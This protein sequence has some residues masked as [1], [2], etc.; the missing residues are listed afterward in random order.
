MVKALYILSISEISG[1]APVSLVGARARSLGSLF[2]AGFTVPEGFAVTSE[3]LA[4]VMGRSGITKAVASALDGLPGAAPDAVPERIESLRKMFLEV[5]IPAVVEASIRQAYE[6]LAPGLSP[7]VAVRIS[8]AAEGLPDSGFASTMAVGPDEVVKAVHICWVSYFAERAA[9]RA[10][11]GRDAFPEFT[12][13]LVLRAPD[14]EVSG[15]MFTCDP[16][17]GDRQRVVINAGAQSSPEVFNIERSGYSI[18]ERNCG[19]SGPSGLTEEFSRAL[20]RLGA[21]VE[22]HFKAPQEIEW[23]LSEGHFF[24]TGARPANIDFTKGGLTVW[25]RFSLGGSLP[26]VAT[27]FTWSMCRRYLENSA[28]HFFEMLEG[29]PNRVDIWGNIGGRVYLNMSAAAEMLEKIPFMDLARAGEFLGAPIELRPRAAPEPSLL[30]KLAAL[31]GR[32]RAAILMIS[33]K[34]RASRAIANFLHHHEKFTGADIKS[35]SDAALYLKFEEALGGHT[36]EMFSH[37]FEATWHTI[38][39]FSALKNLLARYADRSRPVLIWKL[40]T[41]MG[42]IKSAGPML[43]IWKLGRLAKACELT[44]LIQ[45][46][47]QYSDF[48]SAVLRADGDIFLKRFQ[49]FLDEFGQRCVEEAELSRPRWAENPDAV[50]SMIET[51]LKT[52]DSADPAMWAERLRAAAR[53]AERENERSLP[54]WA[55]P[56]FR[57]LLIRARNTMIER[58]TLKFHI[59]KIFSEARTLAKEAGRRLAE[60]GAIEK[61][62]DVFYLTVEELQK[63]LGMLP[64]TGDPKEIVREHKQEYEN[65]AASQEPPPVIVG[66][67]GAPDMDQSPALLAD[68]VDYLTGVAASF[69]T[70]RGPARVLRRPEEY[71]RLKPGDVI[72]APRM[73]INWAPVLTLAGAIVTES[74]GV[75]SNGAVLAREAGMPMVVSVP[76]ACSV[77]RDGQVIMVD[78]EEGR[79]WLKERPEFGS[80]ADEEKP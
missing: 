80:P 45:T 14:S 62:E 72:V 51:T 35:R 29:A 5:S 20:A 67:A 42:G 8:H 46:R 34:R 65:L 54:G 26:G 44:D 43:D 10:K 68:D 23:S 30:G 6:N 13:V 40:F 58:D 74:G 61:Q 76:H 25:G 70:H 15:I 32:L 77:F 24:I 16:S 7:K 28:Q 59:A 3:A 60:R 71:A 66:D 36:L 37:L 19:E 75:L 53:E 56:L 27:P 31:P 2:R 39:L 22:E 55:R 52:P 21:G 50:Y 38:F 48:T 12:A 49:A 57:P 78:G 9:L 73:D 17:S 4:E 1:R 18:V 47:R 63:I 11:E 33:R 79:V 41:G 69:G 64:F